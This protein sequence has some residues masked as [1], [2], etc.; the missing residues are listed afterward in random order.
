MTLESRTTLTAALLTRPKD[1]KPGIFQPAL[2]PPLPERSPSIPLGAAASVD[3][4]LRKAPT[5][6]KTHFPFTTHISILNIWAGTCTPS[7]Q[8]RCEWDNNLVPSFYGAAPPVF[9]GLGG[10]AGGEGVSTHQ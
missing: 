5:S 8:P 2:P 3:P 6:R 1:L 4:M 7:P 10:G 9:P